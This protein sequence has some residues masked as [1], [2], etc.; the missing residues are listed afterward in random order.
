MNRPGLDGESNYA[1]N[2]EELPVK[3]AL[4]VNVLD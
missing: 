3:H 4:T 2:T 1:G